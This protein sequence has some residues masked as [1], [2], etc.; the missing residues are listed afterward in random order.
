MTRMK[1]HL[2]PA[3]VGLAGLTLLVSAC[4]SSSQSHVAQLGSASTS[5]TRSTRS[6][7]N[8]PTASSQ[9]DGAVAF[10]R[11]MRS[12][13]VP[14]YPDPESAGLIPK[15]TPQQLGVTP[16]ELEA[17]QRACIH[18]VPN[19]G[20]PT[21]TQVQQ[22]RNAMLRYARCVRAHG[23]SNMPDPDSRGHLDIGPGTGVDVNSPRFEAAYQACK[24]RLSP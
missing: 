10:S 2:A 17:A 21:P 13:A 5:T 4:G 14:A 8:P 22:Y 11:C 6:V 1:L 12:H 19:R 23:V 18:L 20:R 9:V 3:L 24:S 15:E 7:S 16:S